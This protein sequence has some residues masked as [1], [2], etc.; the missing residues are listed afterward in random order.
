MNVILLFPGQGSQKPGM[1]RD[2]AA[3][4]PAARETFQR[5]DAAL[6]FA[7]SAL[8]FDGPADELTLT[9]NAQPALFAHGAAAWEIGR[10]HV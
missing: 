1:G 5:V 3:A 4:F 7:L 10:A 8:C 6:S 2:L 9:R